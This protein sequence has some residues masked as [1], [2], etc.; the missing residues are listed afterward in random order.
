M[1]DSLITELVARADTLTANVQA[2]SGQMW[3]LSGL[4]LVAVFGPIVIKATFGGR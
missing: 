3:T 4:L 2:L 1:N